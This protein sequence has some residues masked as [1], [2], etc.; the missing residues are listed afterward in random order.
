MS[1]EIKYRQRVIEYMNE[2]HTQNAIMK[3]EEIKSIVSNIKQLDRDTT[4][5]PENMIQY[6]E[7]LSKLVDTLDFIKDND[8]DYTISKLNQ[9]TKNLRNYKLVSMT[10]AIIGMPL[11]KLEPLSPQE[12]ISIYKEMRQLMED[13]A[14][15][16][17]KGKNLDIVN[18]DE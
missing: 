14:K 11:K 6:F 5:L 1:Y 8:V 16:K 3:D 9:L 2:G 10:L 18:F 7:V 17:T 15:E 4:N 12:Q 13:R